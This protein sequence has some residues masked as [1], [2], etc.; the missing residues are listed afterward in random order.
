MKRVIPNRIALTLF[1]IMLTNTSMFTFLF[2]SVNYDNLTNLLACAS[3]YYLFLFFN[4]RNPNSLM[5]FGICTLAGTLTKISFL[6]LGVILLAILLFRERKSIGQIHL[7]LPK[8]LRPFQLKRVLLFS[9]FVLLLFFNCKLYLGNLL[10]FGKITPHCDQI[11]TQ[12]QCM[13]NR[14]YA[15]NRIV[16][17]YRSGKLTFQEAV[18]KTSIIKHPGDRADALG[19]LKIAK[20]QKEKKIQF[21][22][23][24]QYAF[25]WCRIMLE[26]IFG[27]AAH[28]VIPKTSY[29]L[30]SYILIFLVSIV[31]FIRK[32]NPS[33]DNGYTK[34]IFIITLF[35]ALFLMQYVNYN[36]YVNSGTLGLALQGRYIFPVL[37]PL[38]GLISRYLICCF[39][40]PIQIILFLI[41]SFVFIYGDFPFFLSHVTSNWFF[42]LKF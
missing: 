19:L 24:F 9:A 11:L 3:F 5:G 22:D 20:Y 13:Q 7:L 23:R 33:E 6:P 25:V 40:K 12:E 4:S 15:R 2:A 31:V 27:I 36:S 42:A 30:S 28:L 41:A 18:E 39:K 1:F 38:Y 35:Y 29:F 8:Y 10:L 26:R 34:D 16:S 37:V 17:L 32:W 21:M 14:I